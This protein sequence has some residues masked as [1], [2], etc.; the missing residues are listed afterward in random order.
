MMLSIVQVHFE[1]TLFSLAPDYKDQAC[2]LNHLATYRIQLLGS[3]KIIC[4]STED[5]L[6][7][8]A[9]H[10]SIAKPQPK[11]AYKF[12]KECTMEQAKVFSAEYSMYYGVVHSGDMIYLPPGWVVSEA[13]Q[14]KDPCVGCRRQSMSKTH[15]AVL[16]S[17]DDYLCK[18]GKANN[19]LK[20]VK[21]KLILAA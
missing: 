20:A 4:C 16:E 9:A 12:L 10:H 7:H 18:G 11:D 17:V 14:S 6:L 13:V 15:L 21:D 3:R 1:P 8:L 19:A 2:E 5:V